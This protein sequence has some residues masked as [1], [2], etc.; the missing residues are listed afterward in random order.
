MATLFALLGAPGAGKS[1][2]AESISASTA[3]AIVSLDA[4]RRDP[5]AV[6]YHV[7]SARLRQAELLLRQGRSVVF[8]SCLTNPRTRQRV[9][10]MASRTGARTQLTYIDT[11]LAD[12]LGVQGLRRNPVPASVVQRI[13]RDATVAWEQSASEGWHQRELVQRVH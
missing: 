10:G 3:A 12:C 4:M 8:D 5:E 13:H 2:H 7:L 9:L 1:T 6:T 11:P